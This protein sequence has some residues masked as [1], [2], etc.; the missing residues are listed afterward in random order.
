MKIVILTPRD[1]YTKTQQETLSTMGEVVYTDSRRAYSLQEL[2]DLTRNTDLFAIDPDNLGGFEHSPE[3]IIK[4]LAQN[5][6]IKHLALSTTSYG[7][8]SKQYCQSRGIQ[9]T[10]IP[11]YSTQSVAELAIS[12]LLGCSKHI[13]LTD[14]E[15]QKNNYQLHMGQEVG[16]KTIGI[17][18]LGSIGQCTA[19][20]AQGLGMK[21]IGWNRT[22]RRVSGVKNVPLDT[23]LKQSDFISLHLSDAPETVNFISKTQLSQCKK[24]AIFT[25]VS[26]RDLVDEAEM[27]K[28]LKSGQIASYIFEA[29]DFTN[30]PLLGL[31]NA[32]MFKGFGWYT[33]EA[34]D[35]NKKIWVKNIISLVKGN[36][37]NQ[38][39]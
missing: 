31:T 28:A 29:E 15:T 26:S 25:N 39:Y 9:V 23:L 34:L 27:A 1:E 4:I 24:G 32:L 33:K 12:M 20:L 30:S 14:R 16:G 35:R 2:L 7:Y 5:T 10:N 21:V 37:I 6:S 18:G 36:P 3:I 8:V 17:I 13:F 11:H 22:Q 38:V 19:K